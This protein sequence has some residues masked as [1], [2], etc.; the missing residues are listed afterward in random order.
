MRDR[1]NPD[2]R[3]RTQDCR[4]RAS[5]SHDPRGR[6]LRRCS[7]TD[8]VARADAAR[9]TATGAVPNRPL[10]CCSVATRQPTRAGSRPRTSSD[11]TIWESLP[12]LDEARLREFW[13]SSVPGGSSRPAHT[14]APA[15]SLAAILQA[16]GGSAGARLA[17]W[18]SLASAADPP[19][20]YVQRPIMCSGASAGHV[21]AA[22]RKIDPM[23]P[24][25]NRPARERLPCARAT[26]LP[27]VDAPPLRCVR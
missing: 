6:R 17:N 2:R 5:D 13:K 16:V 21:S 20:L 26:R 8:V 14:S 12:T 19:C 3:R 27:R 15:G 24:S 1:V 22:Q 10:H 11:R 7:W 23:G 4:D 25:H 9:A 18:G